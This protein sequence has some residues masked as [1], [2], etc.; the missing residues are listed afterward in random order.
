MSISQIKIFN[1]FGIEVAKAQ[2]LD[3]SRIK[4]LRIYTP[5]A[6]GFSAYE[7][8]V[9]HGFVGNET[10]WLDSL[11]G[12]PGTT[13]YESAVDT[14][15]SLINEK[16][17]AARI[18]TINGVAHDLSADVDFTV[19]G[20]ATVVSDPT[21]LKIG[22]GLD[23]A[24][25]KEAIDAITDAAADKIYTLR[26]FPSYRRAPNLWDTFE[27]KP[28]VQVETIGSWQH[29]RPLDYPSIFNF[30]K[31]FHGIDF[32]SCGAESWLPFSPILQG[33]LFSCP[34][35][36]YAA[37]FASEAA[38]TGA[39]I[40]AAGRIVAVK[41]ASNVYRLRVLQNS[42][43]A[44]L[45]NWID[46]TPN[47]DGL[48]FAGLI[49]DCASF[50]A[51]Y[52]ENYLDFE[53][54]SVK[55]GDFRFSSGN[56]DFYLATLLGA[57]FTNANLQGSYFGSSNSIS[58]QFDNANLTGCD[59]SFAI[60]RQCGF[61]GTNCQN[62]NFFAADLT[63]SYFVEAALT[64]ANLAGAN[65][66]NVRFTNSTMPGDAATKTDFKA[67]VG[68]GNWDAVTTIWTDGLPIG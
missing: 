16:V 8:A 65:C 1:D 22:V 5:S 53:S 59:F 30:E 2:V 41:N 17:P 37:P 4:S 44:D 25:I 55:F 43:G 29:K 11:K 66:R 49:L 9:S 33:V 34:D 38:L 35:D 45:D 60:A 3:S 51:L 10:D 63:G 32:S 26:L 36:I 39:G 12:E 6:D 46:V 62:V 64:G 7:I 15:T 31:S 19:E 61:N 40:T 42:D 58:C 13:D 56:F 54:A 52:E 23:Y 21:V 68:D 47:F 67:K 27:W 18:I 48:V 20:G 24:T 14:L 57:Y 50:F 28:F